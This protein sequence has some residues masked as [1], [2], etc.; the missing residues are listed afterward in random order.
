MRPLHSYLQADQVHCPYSTYICL[1]AFRG[2]QLLD[3]LPCTCW[4]FPPT[5]VF[6]HTVVFHRGHSGALQGAPSHID[7]ACSRHAVTTLD[8][9]LSGILAVQ[10]LASDCGITCE[11]MLHALLVNTFHAITCQ[12]LFQL[13]FT[14]TSQHSIAKLLLLAG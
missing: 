13:N 14:S 6:V 1:I 8:V 7:S 2:W 11:A 12:A 10:T 9:Y 3:L 5:N 4:K